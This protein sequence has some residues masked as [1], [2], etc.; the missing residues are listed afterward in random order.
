MLNLDQTIRELRAEGH[1]LDNLI[2]AAEDYLRAV[3]SPNQPT[4]MPTRQRRTG[5]GRKFMPEHERKEVS[6]R[7]KAY[8]ASRRAK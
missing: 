7:M 2:A 1:S 8:W 4:P 5:A 3:A 6:R